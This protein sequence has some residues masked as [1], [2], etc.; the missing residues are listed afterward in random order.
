MVSSIDTWLVSFGHCNPQSLRRDSSHH[1]RLSGDASPLSQSRPAMTSTGTC[2]LGR[3]SAC[4]PTAYF[5]ARSFSEAES[6]STGVAVPQLWAAFNSEPLVLTL[7]ILFLCRHRGS[8][9]STFVRQRFSQDRPPFTAA[10]A[11]KI[12]FGQRDTTDRICIQARGKC[13]NIVGRGRSR[14]GGR[15]AERA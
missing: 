1:H 8:P 5:D 4:P 6:P 12:W 15:L 2:R 3:G 14:D 11:A 13:A 7:K 9:S 10:G